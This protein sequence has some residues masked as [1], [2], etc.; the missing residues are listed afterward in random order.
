MKAKLIDVTESIF[1]GGD[2]PKDRFS[3]TA[4]NEYKIPIYANAEKDNGLYGY[5]D[6]AKVSV[7]CVTV[8]ARGTIGF[9]AKRIEPF[10]PVV[11]L[12]TVIPDKEKI[13]LDYLYYALRNYRP[14]SSG[15]SIPQL[16][17]PDIK[18]YSFEIKPI[19]KQKEITQIL[20][21]IE[22]LI[23]LKR[24]QI[25]TCDVLIK[26]RFAEMFGNPIKN[27]RGWKTISCKAAT[28]KLGSGATPKGGSEN[29]R[30]E[31]VSLIRSM[32]IYS[33]K[34]EYKELAYINDEQ[35]EKLNS[36]T[37][38]KR[39][40]LL[41]ITGA[42]VARCCIVPEKILP[43]RVNQHVSIIRC[44]EMLLPEFLCYML[45]EDNYQK[46]LWNIATS[47]GATREAITKQQI[48][49]LIFIVPP[50]EL[51]N[52]FAD[53]VE[54]TIKLK[55]TIQRSLDKLHLLFDALMQKYFG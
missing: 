43:A 30:K 3:E 4:T 29:Y 41:N 50:I 53:F 55:A 22:L 33:N 2:V 6:M 47:N 24:K 12:I 45:T 51:Q 9:T 40:V 10:L 34:F 48:E 49:K 36:V 28:S 7:P 18:N 14:K 8:A 23:K 52:E 1:A 21:K 46:Q 39:D 19:S 44:K 13:T 27:S 38:E 15:T 54:Q 42:S 37:V 5:T 11:R 20:D 32:N 17:V 25:D 35:A 26:S 31:G 16:T